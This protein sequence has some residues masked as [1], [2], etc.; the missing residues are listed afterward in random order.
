ME[1]SHRFFNNHACKYFPCHE[2]PSKNAFNCL[3]CY[4]PLYTLED[5]CGG[6]FEYIKGSKSCIDC[7][8]PH[9]PD[10]YDT[11]LSMLK[12]ARTKKI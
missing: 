4:C 10:Y 2:K 11:I 1:N 8:L 9:T 3:F 6:D 5:K 12:K 7:H